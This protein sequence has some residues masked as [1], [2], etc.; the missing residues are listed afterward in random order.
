MTTTTI[1]K[2]ALLAEGLFL[3][4]TAPDEG[5]FRRTVRSCEELAAWM[6]KEEVDDAKKLALIKV[7]GTGEE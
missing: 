1:D 5:R 4:I 3:A 7:E 6:S 2:V